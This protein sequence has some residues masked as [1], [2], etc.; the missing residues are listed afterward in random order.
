MLVGQT[1]YCDVLVLNCEY[2]R[3]V[4][5]LIRLNMRIVEHCSIMAVALSVEPP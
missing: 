3:S 1:L 2:S 5:S 4:R